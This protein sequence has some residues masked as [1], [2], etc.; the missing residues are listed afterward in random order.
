M[1]PAFSRTS[2]II[3]KHYHRLY[4]CVHCCVFRKNFMRELH[5]TATNIYS[6]C[7]TQELRLSGVNLF[8]YS[9]SY[10][11]QCLSLFLSTTGRNDETER[12]EHD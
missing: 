2:E 5:I 4:R 11:S 10:L 6:S 1:T 7:Y 12:F 9:Q 8:Y 3:S